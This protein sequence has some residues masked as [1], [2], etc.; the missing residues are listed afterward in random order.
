MASQGP[1]L[2]TAIDTLATPGRL[3]WDDPSRVLLADSIFA[4]CAISPQTYRL[5]YTLIATGFGFTLPAGSVPTGIEL[6]FSCNTSLGFDQCRDGTASLVVDG[7]TV[8]QITSS[9]V[10]WTAGTHTRSIGGSSNLWGW[11]AANLTDINKVS[12]GVELDVLVPQDAAANIDWLKITVTYATTTYAAKEGSGGAGVGATAAILRKVKVQTT[13]GAGVGGSIGKKYKMPGRGGAGIGGT[14]PWR[15]ERAYT[16]TGGAGVGG[17]RGILRVWRSGIGGAGIGG[18]AGVLQLIH[19][20]GE[21][22]TGIG[23][24]G[25]VR[26]I[27]AGGGGAG[28]GGAA[29]FYKTRPEVASGGFGVGGPEATYTTTRSQAVSGGFGV[30]GEAASTLRVRVSKSASGGLGVGGTAT[31]RV[32]QA[33]GDTDPED[34]IVRSHR[35][36]VTRRMVFEAIRKAIA[37]GPL[38]DR[39]VYLSWDEPDMNNLP[40]GSSFA[41]IMPGTAQ[42]D[43]G[44]LAGG[45]IYGTIRED[46]A[47]VRVYSASS[48]DTA[49]RTTLW[50]LKIDV[51]AM[52]RA[53]KI[54]KTLNMLDLIDPA[55]WLLLAEP[56]RATS[57]TG[58][59]KR[60]TP[61]W[62]YYAERF[63]V[64]YTEYLG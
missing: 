47:E 42:N 64:I 50:N 36:P 7:S 43:Q 8:G 18:T 39:K 17:S 31:R 11:T 4:Q 14:G 1:F 13:G 27:R 6:T 20:P 46:V 63:G 29:D 2:P 12:F 38:S 44:D 22:G 45:G 60:D 21:G 61:N 26:V 9:G 53:R 56:M 15:R 48:I 19:T 59:Q 25:I 10:D 57:T 37:D 58:T 35:G 62:G 55:G 32:T 30:G 24:N 34:D 41:V 16:A 54:R 40:P 3:A 28:V 49:R 52:E 51:S 33:N 5:S 23:G